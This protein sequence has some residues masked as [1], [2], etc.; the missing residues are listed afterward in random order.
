MRLLATDPA[1]FFDALAQAV[2]RYVGT[3]NQAG[4]IREWRDAETGRVVAFS[5]EIAKGRVPRGR[6]GSAR[7]TE[8][9]GSGMK[10]RPRRPSLR[11]VLRGQWFYATDAARANYAWFASVD[12]LVRRAVADPAVDVVDLGPS[13]S[14]AFSALKA[15]YGFAS[16]DDWPDVAD[17]TGP[18][19]YEGGQRTAGVDGGLRGVLEA[20]RARG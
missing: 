12:D 19:R 11:R 8:T 20:L 1:R 16:V 2:G 15:K 18:F 6:S 7:R 10:L 9:R 14:D 3:T 4:V 5:H 17:Y 13:G